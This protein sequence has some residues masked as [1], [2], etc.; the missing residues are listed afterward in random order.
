[1][2]AEREV[3][4]WLETT[5]LPEGYGRPMVLEGSVYEIMDRL[6]HEIDP[7]LIAVGAHGRSSLAPTLLGSYTEELMRR[8]PCDLLVVRR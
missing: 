3:D 1:M 7:D 5:D 4:R 6:N 2:D 8:P